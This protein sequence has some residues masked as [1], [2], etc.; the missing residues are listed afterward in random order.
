MISLTPLL[1]LIKGGQPAGFDRDWFRQIE[2]AAEYAQRGIANVPL[3]ACWLIRSNDT[4]QHAGERAEDVELHFEAV[5]AITNVRGHQPGEMDDQLLRYRK[6]VKNI[7]LGYQLQDT[8][9]PIRF[10]G[11][12]VIEYTDGDLYWRDRYSFNARVD[13]YLPDPAAQFESLHNTNPQPSL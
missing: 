5:I 6:A 7:L 1:Q 13:N 11:G 10:N 12:Q 8:S 4:V 9:L 3:P 2:G